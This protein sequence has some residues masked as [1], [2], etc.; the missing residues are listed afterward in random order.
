MKDLATIERVR[1]GKEY[2]EGTIL[3]QVSAS[4]GQTIYHKGGTAETH[5]VAIEVNDKE[6]LKPRFLYHYII[7]TIEP[8]LPIIRTGIN[9]Q[10]EEIENYPIEFPINELIRR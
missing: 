10:V 5:Y 8:Y 4:R 3:I 1:K 2:P 7:Q 6:K 9:I